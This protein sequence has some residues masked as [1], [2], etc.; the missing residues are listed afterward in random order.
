MKTKISLALMS[1]G[2]WACSSDDSFDCGDFEV[3]PVPVVSEINL[4]EAEKDICESINS[5]GIDFFKIAAQDKSEI[6]KQPNF[7]ISPLSLAFGLSLFANTIDDASSATYYEA[8]GAESLNE[9]NATCRKLMTFLPD[10]S[11][12]DALD[13]VNAVWH[14]P[15]ISPSEEFTK[16]LAENYFSKPCQLDFT[17]SNAKDVINRWASGATHGMIPKFVDSVDPYSVL[18]VANAMYFAGRWSNPFDAKNTKV[19]PFYADDKQYEVEMMKQS[20]LHAPY[21][22]NEKFEIFGMGYKGK[23]AFFAVLPSAD[24]SIDELIQS[25]DTNI[26]KSFAEN[27]EIYNLTVKMPKFKSE[28]KIK[29]NSILAKKGMALD[30]IKYTGFNKDLGNDLQ[31]V[32][33]MQKTAIILDEEGTKAAAVTGMEYVW[34]RHYPA[35]EI[36]FDRPFLYFIRNAVT[37]SI[38]MMGQYTRPE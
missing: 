5:F 28:A 21:W 38:L 13:L 7:S 20:G 3:V 10:K 17:A 2:L 19:A 36:T 30:G 24:S 34:A 22:K 15:T 12:Q 14:K 32:S 1:L 8:L 11:N 26:F 25:F 33:F 16:T 23:C 4:N 9:L 31:K 18:F 6:D 35:A 27:R 29:C 37:G